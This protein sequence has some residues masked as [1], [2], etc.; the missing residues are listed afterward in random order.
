MR[1]KPRIMTGLLTTVFV[2][3]AGLVL[4]QEP[5]PPP[6]QPQQPPAV[7]GQAELQQLQ[8][9]AQQIEARLS[10]IAQQALQAD[11]ELQAMQDDLETL[12]R[13]KLEEFGYPDEAKLAELQ[14]MQ[15]QLQTAEGMDPAERDALTQEFQAEV[16]QMQQA[17]MQAQQDTE[18]QGAIAEVQDARTEAMGE[19]DPEAPALQQ[20]LEQIIGQLQQIQQQMM[21]QQQQHHQHQH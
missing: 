16:T 3:G 15:R 12:Y 7:E 1:D 2:G 6:P 8:Q 9:R 19:I 5:P 11:P 21:Q 17:Q 13:A 20:Q 10:E 14:A 4:A 18:I